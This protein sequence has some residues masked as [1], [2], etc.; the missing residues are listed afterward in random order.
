M[1]SQE[2]VLLHFFFLF[3][4][5]VLSRLYVC[6]FEC[7][8]ECIIGAKHAVCYLSYD[9]IKNNNSKREVQREITMKVVC[10]LLPVH[11]TLFVIF[12]KLVIDLVLSKRNIFLTYK[13]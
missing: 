6:L 9:G 2:R 8:F 5:T 1:I 13:V 11:T 12:Y 7:L 3:H 10:P 4:C